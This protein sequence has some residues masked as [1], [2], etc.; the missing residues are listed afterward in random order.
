MKLMKLL[1]IV[2]LA[3]PM[4]NVL[5]FRPSPTDRALHTSF[6]EAKAKASSIVAD[7]MIEQADALVELRMLKEQ[8][9]GMATGHPEAGLAEL[10]NNA[11]EKITEAEK[12]V[13]DRYK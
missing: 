13:S 1:A 10:K 2:L 8:V 7:K 3:I 12:A 6:E 5:A 4:A 9:K 11:M